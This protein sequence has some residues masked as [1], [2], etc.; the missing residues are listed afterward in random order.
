MKIDRESHYISG[1]DEWDKAYQEHIE[2]KVGADYPK[3]NR[4]YKR[5]LI[6]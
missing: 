6:I 1:E 3:K 2:Q 5:K 4:R